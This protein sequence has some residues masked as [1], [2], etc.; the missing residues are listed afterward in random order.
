[1]NDEMKILRDNLA[2]CVHLHFNKF[3][4]NILRKGQ[5]LVLKTELK[6]DDIIIPVGETCVVEDIIGYGFDIKSSESVEFRIMNS[7]M[8][9][10]FNSPVISSFDEGH[11]VSGRREAE[12]IEYMLWNQNL[13]MFTS[14]F[15]IKNVVVIRTGER[16]YYYVDGANHNLYDPID[17]RQEIRMGENEIEKYCQLQKASV[18]DFVDV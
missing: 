5:K 16:F 6:F 12:L 10:Y 8:G 2:I 17:M 11:R 9:N 18:E 3:L 1:M 14:D 7:V 4:E 13:I 15:E